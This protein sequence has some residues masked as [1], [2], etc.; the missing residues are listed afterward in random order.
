MKKNLFILMML[1]VG[2][3][4]SGCK[5][6]GGNSKSG[7]NRYV[8]TKWTNENIAELGLVKATGTTSPS[9]KLKGKIA[10]VKFYLVAKQ[11]PKMDR[12]G[13]SD[14]LLHISAPVSETSYI[15]NG[16]AYA[17]SLD[18][19]DTLVKIQ[20]LGIAGCDAEII[21]YKDKTLIT[22]FTPKD[23]EMRAKLEKD[24]ITSEIKSLDDISK[25][26]KTLPI[27]P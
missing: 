13:D 1:I 16:D 6:G 3:T 17:K 14:K 25:Y 8:Q 12:V 2:I 19:L 4:L 5:S 11:A 21:N 15:F 24:E 10:I 22:K 9:P 23:N 18:E 26:L 20:C 27:E 7:G